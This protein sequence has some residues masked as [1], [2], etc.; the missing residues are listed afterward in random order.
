MR[1]SANLNN[2]ET[3]ASGSGTRSHIGA[4]DAVQNNPAR[5]AL[6]LDTVRRNAFGNRENPVKPPDTLVERSRLA[7]R[8]YRQSGSWKASEKR[9]DQAPAVCMY[10]V[11]PN[12]PHQP[13]QP[14]ERP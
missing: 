4:S 8:V 5:K 1:Q 12:S 14:H 11:R 7:C 13:V 6:Q 3:V 9:L 2:P 10:D